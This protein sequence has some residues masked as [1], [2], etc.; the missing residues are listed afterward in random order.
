MAT[1]DFLSHFTLSSLSTKNGIGFPEAIENKPKRKSAGLGL[2]VIRATHLL[3]LH[4]PEVRQR[5]EMAGI[6]GVSAPAAHAA[7][8]GC[9]YVSP[10]SARLSRAPASEWARL[11][12]SGFWGTGTGSQNGN[13][14]LGKAE[15]SPSAAKA[16][17]SAETNG[18]TRERPNAS[19]GRWGNAVI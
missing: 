7:R 19:R 3:D 4:G 5:T 13:G 2:L 16:S 10:C 11:P 12:S 17:S 8:T 18:R 1:T 14:A 6:N 9:G 15:T